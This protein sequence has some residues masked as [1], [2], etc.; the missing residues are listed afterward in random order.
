MTR[1]AVQHLGRRPSTARGVLQS[2]ALIVT[3]LIASACGSPDALPD[4]LPD[5]GFIDVPGGRIAFRVMGNGPGLPLLVIHGGPG[6]SSCIYP[7]TLRGIAE[8]RPVIMYDQLGTGYSDRITDLERYAVVPRFVEE[9]V[10]IRE[11]LGL[12]AF[13]IL[14]HSWG[15]S[16][17][18][19]YLLATEAAGVRSAI[20]VGP[21][22]GTDRWL[23]DANALVSELSDESQAAIR[24]AIAS[25]DFSTP[26][27]DAANTE[28]MGQFGV[29]DVEA[30]EAIEECAVRPPGDS[31]LYEYMW[32]PSEFVS[33]GT[34]RDYDRIDRLPELDVPV[35]FLAGEYDEARPGTMREFQRLVDGSEVV[36]IPDAGHVSNVDQPAAF[37]EA[38]TV[39]LRRIEEG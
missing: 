9:V 10:A 31:G 20:F 22:V 11:S 21:L 17:T 13:H 5:D 8:H 14:G 34:L 30:Y 7:S 35:L 28:F 6:S 19:E 33:T 26:D 12:E 16:V 23:E 15:G 25:G 24:A 2:G 36:I 37:N 27:F 29:R 38:V 1:S 3:A 18:M 32:G 39:F 4:A